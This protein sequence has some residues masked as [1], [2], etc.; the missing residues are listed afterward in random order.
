MWVVKWGNQWLHCSQ[1]TVWS[2]LSVY[3]ITC[4]SHL[5]GESKGCCR[6]QRFDCSPWFLIL[7][8]PPMG[9][10]TLLIIPTGQTWGNIPQEGN[11]SIKDSDTQ[12][13]KVANVF[14]YAFISWVSV[15]STA[16]FP[17]RANKCGCTVSILQLFYLKLR[18]KL[19]LRLQCDSVMELLYAI[20]MQVW[21]TDYCIFMDFL[22]T[23]K[24]I[25]VLTAKQ[26]S[27]EDNSF[28]LAFI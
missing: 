7:L 4:I 5:F 9:K 13:L 12:A 19:M 21:V 10:L 3:I 26:E 11:M 2:C 8:H 17:G 6:F 23:K 20:R 15:A 22:F 1:E 25:T 24:A 18:K 16:L 28:G 27:V 14:I